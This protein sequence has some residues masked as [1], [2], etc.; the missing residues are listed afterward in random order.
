MSMPQPSAQGRA[1]ILEC[2]REGFAFIARDWRAI[3]PIAAIGAAAM[4]PLEVWSQSAMTRFDLGT[5]LLASL[6]T[7]VVQAPVLAAYLRRALSRGVD[8]LALR[9]GADERNVVGVSLSLAFFFSIVIVVSVLII[10]A[11]LGALLAGSGMDPESMQR[12]P[13]EER[14]QTFMEALGNDG[15]VVLLTLAAAVLAGLIWLSARLALAVPATVAEGR[16]RAFS[17][18]SWT[19]G[20]AAPIAACLVLV[21]L[22][23]VLLSRLLLLL[24]ALAVGLLMGGEAA[25][26]TPGSPAYWVLAYIAVFI[27]LIVFH[28]PYAAMTAYLYRGLRPN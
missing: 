4:T 15:R 8:P 5:A 17:T 11:A 20:N 9:L 25:L 10:G 16:M 3:V 12:L 13:A 24:P 23:A 21:T 26:T 7:V 6:L 18:W 2:V 1:P 14:M 27:G 22:G 28:A 19:R